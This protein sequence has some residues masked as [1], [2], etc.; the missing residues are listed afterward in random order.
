MLQIGVFGELAPAEYGHPKL[1]YDQAAHQQQLA[2]G[3]PT[4]NADQRRVFDTVITAGRE[5]TG[6]T[7]FLHGPGGNGKT[8]LQLCCSRKCVVKGILL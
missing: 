5:N 2:P 4:R 7:F 6:T 1:L 8:H 3:I